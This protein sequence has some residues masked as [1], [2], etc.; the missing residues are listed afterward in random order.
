MIDYINAT[1]EAH[2]LTIEDPIE[3]VH[4]HKKSTV[5]QRELG[6]DTKSFEKALKSALRQA[7]DVI[8][9]GEMRDY[10]TIKA[11][12]TAA[13][14]GHLV[15]GTLHTN[16]APQ[17]VD[18]IIDVMPEAQQAQVR[19]QLAESIVGIVTQTLL[20][21]R[22]APGRVIAYEILVA[23]PAIRA[24]I[25]EGK[26]NQIVSEMQTG[27]ELGMISFNKVLARLYVE[28]KV[29][30]EDAAEK[31]TDAKELDSFIQSLGGMV[32]KPGETR[33]PSIAQPATT[34]GRFGR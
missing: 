23:T 31:A 12:I 13:E 22:G 16:T 27:A 15:M 9:V 32:P 2:I 26:T 24:L 5:E 29:T 11:A 17:T 14:T 20:P 8:L 7:P 1:R 28:G 33:A 4:K 21:R 19:V 6:R 18:R 30:Y 10:E 3:I 25:R 34:A